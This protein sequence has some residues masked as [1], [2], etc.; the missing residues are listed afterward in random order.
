M[1]GG[2]GMDKM[3]EEFETWAVNFKGAFNLPLFVMK[4]SDG[5]Y[6]DGMAR[7]AWLAWQASRAALVVE[8]PQVSWADNLGQEC[9]LLDE[10]TRMLDKAGIKYE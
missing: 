5:V 2:L 6:T 1:A 3:R 9:M 7:I 10:V 8:L 4:D